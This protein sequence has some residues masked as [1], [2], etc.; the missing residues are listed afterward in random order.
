MQIISLTSPQSFTPVVRTNNTSSATAYGSDQIQT[1]ISPDTFSG[2]VKQAGAEPEVRPDVVESFK[3]RI[4]SGSYP[5]A[6]V[7]EGLTHLIG[8]SVMQLASSQAI[9]GKN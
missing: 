3:A 2:L 7:V 5:P 8:A 6:D 1:D 4:S 9:A